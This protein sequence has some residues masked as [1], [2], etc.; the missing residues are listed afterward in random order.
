MNHRI[1]L[2]TVALALLTMTI[3]WSHGPARI[4]G[5]GGVEHPRVPIVLVQ[6]E[7]PAGRYQVVAGRFTSA[8][9]AGALRE[10]LETNLGLWPVEISIE[11][12]EFAVH[13]GYNW[14]TRAE[15]ESYVESLQQLGVENLTI[16][17][18]QEEPAPEPP[19]T[20]TDQERVRLISIQVNEALGQNDFERAAELVERWRQIE[21]DNPA[22]ETT[23]RA[24]AARE[25][26]AATRAARLRREAQAAE[27]AG[28]LE[29]ALNIWRDYRNESPNMAD[30]LEARENIQRLTREIAR[31]ETVPAPGATTGAGA[32][33][34]EATLLWV[35]IAVGALVVAVVGYLV[36]FRKGESG[37]APVPAQGAAAP[38]TGRGFGGTV[39]VTGKRTGRKATKPRQKPAESAEEAPIR[40]GAV[41]PG[42]SKHQPEPEP[43]PDPLG[44]EEERP[45]G[46]R[47]VIDDYRVTSTTESGNGADTPRAPSSSDAESPPPA[48]GAAT[49]LAVYLEQDFEDEKPGSPPSNW[50]GHYDYARLLVEERPNGSES[51]HCLLFEKERGEGGAIYSCRFPD[52][53]GIV[54]VEFDLQCEHKNKYLLGFYLERDGDFRQ[55]VPLLIH[56]EAGGEERASL[57]V[58]K[59]SVP[60]ELGQWVHVRFVVDLPRSIVDWYIDGRQVAIGVRLASRVHL[61][62]TLSIRDNQGTAGSLR[63]DNIRVYQER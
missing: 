40:P 53:E 10:N 56:K 20:P 49:A 17:E 1:S 51:R 8:R 39:P 35:M 25:D 3:S 18:L 38:T 14:P 19:G 4:A 42:A 33:G 47:I 23:L 36:L 30:Q 22:I 29:T 6:N 5:G 44:Q 62:N 58:Q 48:T 13:V 32:G 63:L 27:E 26:A 34:T 15:A 50:E 2:A 55:S 45:S 46:D 7:L 16:V 54:G 9:E 43:E 21:P 31:S 24:I 11:G 41:L 28:N 37:A 60:Y 52:A 59:E 61:L 57:R 12:D